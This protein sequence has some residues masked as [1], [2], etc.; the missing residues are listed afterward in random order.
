[1][2]R[3]A[4]ISVPIP[5]SV[6]DGKEEAQRVQLD[7]GDSASVASLLKQEWANVGAGRLAVITA[8]D[9]HETTLSVAQSVL[10]EVVSHEIESQ[11]A[12]LSA[13]GAKGLEF[14]AVVVLEPSE[15]LHQTSRGAHHLYVAL[16]RATQRLVLAHQGPLPAGL[17][18]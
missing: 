4:N 6:R 9:R 5:N 7:L 8:D 12:V 3:E 11:V 15:I 14:D 18:E 13:G 2:L 1:M 10:G 16:T 17:A